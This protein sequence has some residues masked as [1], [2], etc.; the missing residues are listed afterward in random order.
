MVMSFPLCEIFQVPTSQYLTSGEPLQW[1]I[2]RWEI[3]RNQKIGVGF[4]SEVYKG[5][6]RGELV[7]IKV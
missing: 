7:A 1:T 4:F 2:T 5:E 3:D 6:W